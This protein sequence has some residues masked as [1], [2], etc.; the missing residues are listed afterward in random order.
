M[1]NILVA[2]NYSKYLK[3]ADPKLAEVIEALI[4][5]LEDLRERVAELEAP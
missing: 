4:K 3:K 1:S 2:K 5:E